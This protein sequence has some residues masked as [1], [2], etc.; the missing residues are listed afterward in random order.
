MIL[1]TFGNVW[2]GNDVF[3]YKKIILVY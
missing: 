1:G 2:Y 3:F